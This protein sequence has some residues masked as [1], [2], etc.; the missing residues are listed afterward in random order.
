MDLSFLPHDLN[1]AQKF[2]KDNE[3]EDNAENTRAE[4]L[5][6]WKS[7][8]IQAC[9]GSGKT[10]I[11]VTKLAWAI[12]NW[13]LDNAGI[14]VLSHTNVAKDEIKK[15]LTGSQA[16]KLFSY[17]HFVGTIQ[18][19]IDKFVA[20]PVMRSNSEK[21]RLI[22]TEIHN[23]MAMF[24]LENN[25]DA[26]I[27]KAK[28]WQKLKPNIKII[29]KLRLVNG[30]LMISN[31]SN[32]YELFPLKDQPG[33]SA[34]K[35]FQKIKSILRERGIYC[36]DEILSIAQNAIDK[37]LIPLDSIQRRF[38]LALIDEAQDTN[39]IQAK[40]LDNILNPK[41]I[42]VIRFGDTDQQIFE[43]GEQANTDKF[44]R[45]GHLTISE[46]QRCSCKISLAANKLSLS[47]VVIQ[48]KQKSDRGYT[49]TVIL[50]DDSKQEN[51][52]AVIQKFFDLLPEEIKSNNNSIV[53]VIGQIGEDKDDK[54]TTTYSRTICD[55]QKDFLKP[56]NS[57][58]TGR[59]KNLY[60]AIENSRKIF[61]EKDENCQAINMF[62]SSLTF[63]LSK[64][65]DG[66]GETPYSYR[67]LKEQLSRAELNN[68]TLNGKALFWGFQE[69]YRCI[70]LDSL[71]YEQIEQRIKKSADIHGFTNLNPFF[72]GETTQNRQ[73]KAHDH[74]ELDG[75]TIAL[76][77]I[78]GVKGET[79]TATLI[80]ETSFRKGH[81]TKIALLT[82][83][84]GKL[85]DEKRI[86]NLYVAMTRPTD[87]LCLAIPVEEYT[88]LCKN[89]NIK[90]WFDSSF[91]IDTTL[92]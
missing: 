23:K 81:N 43:F 71:E 51:A 68:D 62:F 45:N 10:T 19:F 7:V 56:A 20:L 39:E 79:H 29:D 42:K 9:P 55:Y 49:P 6:C 16:S 59:A 74:L 14:C 11:L 87:F 38:P 8:D 26:S 17:P 44:P 5:C 1:A 85:P 12:E 63:L 35:G 86:K 40:L 82:K 27:K 31:D 13:K 78:A 2:L 21:I 64:Y 67:Y 57:S 34:Y 33:L 90:E 30:N 37:N 4:I 24:L 76:N 88:K 25:P 61:R 73:Q 84:D 80:L 65:L 69:I 66:K 83:F 15:R 3:L 54:E 52:Q 47:D 50:F 60:D 58:R 53:K 91:T 32:N 41:K 36:Y 75:K 70:V 77:T 22:D 89:K 92:E 48:S 72:F 28:N 18:E 46:T